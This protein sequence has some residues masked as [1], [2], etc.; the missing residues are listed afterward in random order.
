MGKQLKWTP[1][2]D[3]QPVEVVGGSL[4]KPPAEATPV[5]DEKKNAST[6]NGPEPENGTT[7][8]GSTDSSQPAPPDTAPTVNPWEVAGTVIEGAGGVL[9]KGIFDAGRRIASGFTDDI[10]KSLAQGLEVAKSSVSPLNIQ[11]Y[12]RSNKGADFQRYVREKE[13]I[14]FYESFGEEGFK[15][16]LPKYADQYMNESGL[17]DI[18]AKIKVNEPKVIARRLQTEKIVQE[19]NKDS[20]EKL[21]GTTQ[22][23]KNIKSLS[24]FASYIGSLGGQAIYQIPLSIL[25]KGSSSLIQESA[26]VYDQQLDNLAADHGISREEVIKRGLDK[27]AE[28]QAYAVLAAFL[29]RLSAGNILKAFKVGGG[30]I[31]AKWAKTAIPE[32]VTEPAQGVLEDVGAATGSKMDALGKAIT[33]AK[34]IDELAGGIVGGSVG[35]FSPSKESV[36]TVIEQEKIK[37]D[38]SNP[39]SVKN[40]AETI[41]NK[42]NEQQKTETNQPVNDTQTAQDGGE[43]QRK[44]SD[45]AGVKEGTQSVA[46][47]DVSKPITDDKGTYDFAGVGERLSQGEEATPIETLKQQILN[48]PEDLKWN[49]DGKVTILT[50]KGGDMLRQYQELKKQSPA[51]KPIDELNEDVQKSRIDTLRSARERWATLG[52]ND[53]DIT[54]QLAENWNMSDLLPKPTTDEQNST[55]QQLASKPTD[56]LEQEPVGSREGGT[57][58]QD[59]TGSPATEN[60]QSQEG[61][62][63]E[64]SVAQSQAPPEQSAPPVAQTEDK[65]SYT[66]TRPIAPPPDSASNTVSPTSTP[67]TEGPSDPGGPPAPDSNKSSSPVSG[68]RATIVK[69]QEQ[70]TLHDDM[71]EGIEDFKEYEVKKQSR[72]REQAQK[73]IKRK[74]EDQALQDAISFKFARSQEEKM[75]LLSELADRFST[76]FKA[77][78]KAGNQEQVDQ[79]YGK[80]MTAMNTLSNL[81]TDTAQALSYLNLVGTVFETKTGAVRFA[82]NQ[83]EQSREGAMKNHAQLKMTA[84]ELIKQFDALPKEEFLKSKAVQD[85]IAQLKQKSPEGNKVRQADKKL[86]D[87]ASKLREAVAAYK[88]QGIIYDPKSEAA[89]DVAVTKALINYVKA[90]IQKLAIDVNEKIQN[91]TAKVVDGVKSFTQ[92]I[93]MTITDAQVDELVNDTVAREFEKKYKGDIRTAVKD[94]IEKKTGRDELIQRIIDTEGITGE[95]ATEF[96]DRFVNI[97]EEYLTKEKQKLV[98]HYTPKAKKK[99]AKR[100]EF[101]DKVI[102]LSNAGAVSDE[103]MDN[104]IAEIFGLPGMSP[105]IVSNIEEMVDEINKAPVGRFKNIAITKMTDYIAKQQRFNLSDYMLASFRAGI[106]SGVDTQALNLLGNFFNV[107]EMGAMMTM[108]N[109]K[110]GARFIASVRNPTSLAKAGLE[111]LEIM[112]TGFDPRIAGDSKRRSLEQNERTLFGLTPGLKGW[113]QA[114]DPTLEQQKKYVFRALSAGDILFSQGI[115]DALQNE[116]YARRAKELK[117]ADPAA[118]VREQM[119]FTPENI[120]HALDQANN[121]ALAGQ[122]PNDPTSISLR[123]K[124]IIEQQRDP[125]IV[126][127]SR[128]YAQEQILTNSPKGYIGIVAR[129]INSIIHSLPAF[130][131]LIPVVNFAANAMQRAVQYV[132]PAALARGAAHYMG[133]AVTGESLGSIIRD[134][135]QRLKSGDLEQEMRLRRFAAG[136]VSLVIMAALLDDDDDGDNLLSKAVGKTVK[137][138]GSGP[139]TKLN[140]QKTYQKQETGYLPYSI[141]M[142]DVYIPYKNY[143]GLNVLLSTFG[144]YQDA[145]RYGKLDNKDALNRMV[146]A[147]CNSFAV[148]SEMGFLTSLNTTTQAFLEANPK[149]FTSLI[150]RPI[151]G[152][153]VPKFQRNIINFFDDQVYSGRDV[154]EIA[155]RSIPLLNTAAGDPL[156]NALGENVERNWW[157]RIELWNT[158]AYSAYKPIWK[159][160]A[161]KNYY[162]TVPSKASLEN[163]FDKPIS[164][165]TYNKFFQLRGKE[166]VKEFDPKMSE[167]A[168]EEYNRKMDKIVEIAKYRAL[169]SMGVMETDLMKEIRFQLDDIMEIKRKSQELRKNIK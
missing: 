67:A 80:F 145:K 43:E 89:K 24:D 23:Y 100:A 31:A 169:V 2:A 26:T 126:A 34:R 1:P 71:K 4:W 56:Q 51:T 113:K 65:G 112:R 93:G 128:E 33:S 30:S 84:E 153:L 165:E 12:I 156:L 11:E 137:I 164:T 76:K 3:A 90:L 36:N 102:K 142:G 119:G 98:N 131:A 38:T 107:L 22:S 25:T 139:G 55:Q 105:E 123:S 91:V 97:F 136:T 54:R 115:N 95:Q 99:N 74:G 77:A 75:A 133:R 152:L 39:E 121:E 21:A 42:F 60:Q 108:S 114:L 79:Y 141:Q 158:E 161:E 166:I 57:V 129:G 45:N 63:Q 58:V 49:E 16:Y 162:F 103:T 87:A 41:Q 82:K 61:G 147:V 104:T 20:S 111:A 140:R 94:Y 46:D 110:A 134:D 35:V 83:I 68:E 28:G 17:Q 130:S 8:P 122:I 73:Y 53:K 47:Q 44:D 72:S 154:Q 109:P 96:T 37:V 69:L 32:A 144:E 52:Q 13:K 48:S 155:I 62:Q 160:N 15:K 70:S 135:I 163:T 120:N 92:E 117:V 64:A 81:I 5:V 29:D 149:E 148:I 19:Q 127:K 138:H 85:L 7:P 101:Y 167:L 50:E 18:A 146:F 59:S 14:P 118:Y 132:P 78:D 27:P 157:D 9:A 143:P 116:M 150:T 151:G 168:P 6:V 124:E 10:P 86:S 125:D 106:F 40:A 159:A 88:S 66:F